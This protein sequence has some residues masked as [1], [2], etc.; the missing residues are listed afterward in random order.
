MH[1][2]T[3]AVWALAA[4][5]AVQLAPN[6][7][8][9]LIVIGIA[10][11]VVEMQ[12]PDGPLARAYWTLILLSVLFVGFRIA[13]GVVT[14][15]GIG[16]VLFTLPSFT[17][18]SFLGGFAVGGTV[19]TP[20]VLQGL[21]DGIVIVGIVAIFAAF[22]ATVSHY[23]LVQS[24]PR[25]FY[26]GG[27]VVVVAL[28]FVPSTL[29]AIR[30]VREAERARTGGFA[31][32]RGRIVRTIIP[33]LE[34][35]M[36]RALSLAE[37]MDA[38]GFGRARGRTSETAAGWLALGALVGL[39][40]TFVALV[41]HARVTAI[42]LGAIAVVLLVAAVGATSR[43]SRRSRY[44]P[45]KVA[46]LDWAVMAVVVC[47]PVGLGLLSGFGGVDMRW[48]VSPLRRPPFDL[49]AAVVLC[50]LALPALIPAIS[51]ETTMHITPAG[52]ESLDGAANATDAHAI[53]GR[54]DTVAAVSK[55]GVS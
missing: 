44:R 14:T 25:S 7:L 46:P 39:A 49:V 12:A 23:E 30:D 21:A 53:A 51:D 42:W 40:A 11:L 10:T 28:A 45:R 36:E 20:V 33:V 52:K 35:G 41:A 3:L 13:L 8:Y 38:R 54:D 4:T 18:P 16:H 32:R 31:T 19:E 2:A 50:V 37:S 47:V 29:S 17:L 9:V 22:N 5:A 24:S 26:E 27:L 48:S 1:A 34:I 55:G 15:H 6:P 43:T